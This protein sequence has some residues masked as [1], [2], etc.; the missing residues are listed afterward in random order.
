[1]KQNKR[2]GFNLKPAPRKQRV[3]LASVTGLE[4]SQL[5]VF[6]G[7]EQENRWFVW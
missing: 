3:F 5:G 6:A 1:L 4:T 7:L 2:G